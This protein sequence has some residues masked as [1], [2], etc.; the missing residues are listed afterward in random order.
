[1]EYVKDWILSLAAVSLICLLIIN[2]TP[3]EKHL[4]ILKLIVS[5]IFIFTAVSPIYG[6]INFD[7][8]YFSYDNTVY[9]AEDINQLKKE[10]YQK[11]INSQISSVLK[12]MS[13]EAKKISTDINIEEDNCIRINKVMILLDKKYKNETDNVVNNVYNIMGIVPDVSCLNDLE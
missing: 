1:M 7:F 11:H 13:I 6:N 12:N 3:S 9:K 10:I 5:I 8:N 4:N 2:L